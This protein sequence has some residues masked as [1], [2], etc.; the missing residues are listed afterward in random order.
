VHLL[1]KRVLKPDIL[2]RNHSYRTGF[3]VLAAVVMKKPL[4]WDIMPCS[5]LPYIPE[6]RTLH[7]HRCENLKSY[8]NRM[9]FKAVPKAAL[10]SAIYMCAMLAFPSIRN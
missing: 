1:T 8:A 2:S 7:N 10:N 5:L 3:E 9:F 4:F 6:D